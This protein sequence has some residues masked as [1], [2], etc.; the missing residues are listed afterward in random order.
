MLPSLL[1]FAVYMPLLMSTLMNETY[2][3]KNPNSKSAIESVLL[4]VLI[5]KYLY[6]NAF[7]LVL[8][9]VHLICVGKA[10]YLTVFG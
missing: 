7:W 1:E 8:L 6:Q 3:L 2:L 5:S 10:F 9:S 4:H